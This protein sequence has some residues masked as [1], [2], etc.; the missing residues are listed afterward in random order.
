[1]TPGDVTGDGVPDLLATNTAGDLLVYPGN[2]DP[3]LT[4][5]TAG[6]AATSPEPRTGWNKFQITPVAR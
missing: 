3:A 1:M 2:T 5:V 6:T 4:P